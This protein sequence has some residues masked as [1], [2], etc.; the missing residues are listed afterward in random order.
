MD[1]KILDSWLR[2]HIQTKAKTT[3][4]AKALSLTSASVEKIEEYKKD[5]L[6]HIE[7]T[8]NR[9][10]MASVIGIAREAAASLP[11]FSI[12]ATFI[13]L[14]VKQPKIQGVETIVIN[15]NNRLVKRI[16]AVILEL[17]LG[18]SP[19]YIK[20]RLEASGIRSLNNAIDITNY[21]MLEVG[22]PTH[23]FDYDRL[24]TKKLI[25]REA[26][27]GEKIITLDKKEHVLL[28]GDIVA[29]NG[30]G[31]IVDLLGVMGTANSV[32]TNQT[33]RI[34][35]FIDNND[36][37]LIRRTSM[38]LGIR[39][40]AA[41]LNE[42]DV[43]P[44]LAMTALLRG[45]QLYQEI[46]D[47]KV[48]SSIIDIY[49]KKY[50]P[51]TITVSLEK[52]QKITGVPI[53]LKESKAVF[54]N[55]GFEVKELAS[56]IRVT[57]PSWRVHDI[58]IE[59]DVIEEIAR[60]Y[61]YHNLPS[62]LPE[63]WEI[64]P[65]HFSDQFYFEER[66][67]EALKY[68][69][70]TEVYTYSMV[71]ERLYEG[72]IEEAVK[73][74]NPLDED[75]VYMRKTVTPN[76]LEV[77]KENKNRTDVKLFEIANIYKRKS[78]GLPE[79][80]QTI[81]GVLKGKD[82]TFYHT[83]GIVEQL[84]IDLGIKESTWKDSAKGGLGSDVY[85]AKEFLGTIEVLEENLVT[86]ELN[87]QTIS[88]HSTLQKIYIPIAKYPPIVEDL[89]III[90]EKIKTGDI[91][92]KIKKQDTLITDVSLLDTFEN[93]R[94]FHIVYQDKEKNLKS[95]EMGKIREKI[96]ASLE[97]TFHAKLT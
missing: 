47:A 57:I 31:E 38:S 62:K 5:H 11:R 33:K 36:S 35:F 16:C 28:G 66:A 89:S 6:Y 73:L 21:V 74:Q 2:T 58:T 4:I 14:S 13:P 53:T 95:E 80:I 68:W 37:H 75:H 54:A 65:H 85:L 39:T 61:G 49:P 52:I 81:A 82:A 67:K 56:A 60:M 96:I 29:D 88:K 91:I 15:N 27:K 12:P 46:A 71:S 8:T 97:K 72:P 9:V 20:D 23:A 63:T 70:F 42:K 50:T 34:V 94:T 92:D 41:A 19:Q 44:E 10:D 7:V 25:I 69:G 93:K 86:F 79:E 76:L 83:K 48:I 32:V 51:K 55:L 40:D 26:K 18:N 30:K 17:T 59:E 87:F 84:L 77:L 78:K 22:H 3:D 45:I 90:D 64:I 43:D 24:L 1:I